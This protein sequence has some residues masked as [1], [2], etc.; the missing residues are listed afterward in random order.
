MVRQNGA[1]SSA[2]TPQQS[3]SSISSNFEFVHKVRL[4]D[5]EQSAIFK[6]LEDPNWDWRTLPGIGRATGL[7]ESVIMD[8]LDQNQERLEFLQSQE[9]GMLVRLK[10]REVKPAQGI[11]GM[12]DTILD[13]LSLG[14]RTI[15][16][17]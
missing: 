3:G 7:E 13:M 17:S 5:D 2:Y 10:T 4:A 9:F 8:V 1:A 15:V 11:A 6:A 16:Q 14:K 12:L